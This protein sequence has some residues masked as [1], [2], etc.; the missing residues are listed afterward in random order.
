MRSLKWHWQMSDWNH[1]GQKHTSLYQRVFYFSFAFRW[2]HIYIQSFQ[3]LFCQICLGQL[4]VSQTSVFHHLRKEEFWITIAYGFSTI[5]QKCIFIAILSKS[6]QNQSVH[7]SVHSSIRPSILPWLWCPNLQKIMHCLKI[8]CLNKTL[9]YLDF[10]SKPYSHLLTRVSLH[11]IQQW[12]Q[13]KA[14][15]AL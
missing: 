15:R 10:F 4:K 8:L 13:R 11:C 7:P 14:F 1:F 5:I 3:I 6:T 12:P 2:Q 9:I